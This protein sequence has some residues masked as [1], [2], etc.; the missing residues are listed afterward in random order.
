ML[1]RIDKSPSFDRVVAET[2]KELAEI[3]MSFG[4]SANAALITLTTDSVDD[5][6]VFD[7]MNESLRSNETGQR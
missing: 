7:A 5:V 4:R 2:L 3:P 1:S 6:T